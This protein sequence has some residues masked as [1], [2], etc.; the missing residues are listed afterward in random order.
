MHDAAG[1]G[2]L[3][4]GITVPDA[5]KA[6]NAPWRADRKL[7]LE[8]SERNSAPRYALQ[9]HDD[10]PGAATPGKPGLIGPP[11]V[12][13]RGEPVEIEVVPRAMQFLAPRLSQH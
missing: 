7:H 11:I 9:L 13:A 1:M 5:G 12:L 4:L 6:A 2:Q 10:A 3:V 8:I